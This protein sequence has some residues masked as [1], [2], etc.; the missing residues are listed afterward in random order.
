MSGRILPGRR[1]SPWHL[2][3]VGGVSLLWNAYG[4]YDYVMTNLRD[5][6]YLAQ[7]PPE[8]MQVIDSFPIWVTAAWALGVWGALAGSVLLLLRS[9]YAFHGF[10]VSLIGLA[11]SS[12][13]Q[14]SI[15]IPDSLEGGA[16]TAM[17]VVIW[18][19]A[20]LLLV[21]TARMRALRVIT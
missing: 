9:R 13:Y 8:M 11:I 18:V 12:F 6:E 15:D 3:V 2:W 10:T 4:C 7:F 21:Y 16:N 17:Q 20:V 14:W 5:P 1:I 19:V